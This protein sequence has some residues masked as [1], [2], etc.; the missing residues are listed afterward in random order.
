MTLNGSD[1]EVDRYMWITRERAFSKP[2]GASPY[3]TSTSNGSS[4]TAQLHHGEWW[5]G[6]IL[7]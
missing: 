3:I 2:Y 4:C 7:M 1:P 6:R 5:I